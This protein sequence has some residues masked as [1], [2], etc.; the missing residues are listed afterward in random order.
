MHFLMFFWLAYHINILCIDN[1]KFRFDRDIDV[2]TCNKFI[3]AAFLLNFVSFQV[4]V[5]L[6]S[7]KV[8]EK[9]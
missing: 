4:K 8:M 5:A 6:K 2:I 3:T 7:T 1:D 9:S